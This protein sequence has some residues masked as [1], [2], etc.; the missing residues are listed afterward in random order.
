MTT[1]MKDDI[2]NLVLLFF[3][4]LLIS[5]CAG[6]VNADTGSRTVIGNHYALP[7]VST[8]GGEVEFNLY[9]S[10]EGAVVTTRKDLRVAITYSNAYTNSILGVW[11][12][13]GK[14]TLEV[15]VEPLEV[16]GNSATPETL[17]ETSS[18]ED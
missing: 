5:V 12:K 18:S 3:A 11:E 10:T 2:R 16:G 8:T 9:E 7:K 13:F 14:M 4:T 15:E 1:Q 17:N 6:C